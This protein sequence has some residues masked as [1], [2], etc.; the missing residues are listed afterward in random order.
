MSLNTSINIHLVTI[1]RSSGASHRYLAI[2]SLTFTAAPAKF[3]S[4]GGG[5]VPCELGKLGNQL[6][7]TTNLVPKYVAPI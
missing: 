4:A 7:K 6:D 5:T 2:I 1:P 3:L